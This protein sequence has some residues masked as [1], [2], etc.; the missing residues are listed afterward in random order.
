MAIASQR[1]KNTSSPK[2]ERSFSMR[3][4]AFTLVELLVVIAIIGI[5]VGLLLPAV[6]AVR[7]AARRTACTNNLRQLA[8]AIHNYASAQRHFPA[9]VVDDDDNHRRGLHSGTVYLLPYIEQ[10]NLY[11]QYDFSQPWDASANLPVAGVPISLFLC[12]ENDSAV[13]QDGGIAGQP[14]DYAFNKGDEAF[15]G[16]SRT[17][18]GLFDINSKTRFRDIAD[19]SSST[20]LIGEAASSPRLEAE[21]T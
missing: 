8:L 12:P 6:Q 1:L 21:S 20:F 15:L 14:S 16:R 18:S 11:Q 5:L 7:Q 2:P 3:R 4:P 10:D 13:E 9:G 19:G 17:T